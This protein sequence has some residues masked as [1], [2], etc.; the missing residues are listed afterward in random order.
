[1]KIFVFRENAYQRAFA[2]E[3]AL[4]NE[5]EKQYSGR[6]SASFPSHSSAS[7]VD[8]GQRSHGGK[9]GGCVRI[10]QWGML[11]ILLSRDQLESQIGHHFLGGQ[12]S[13]LPGL[14]LT[15]IMERQ[16]F[17]LTGTDT[18]SGYRCAFSDYNSSASTTVHRLTESLIHRHGILHTL[19]LLTA[20]MCNNRLTHGINWFHH[21]PITWE[22]PLL[23]VSPLQLKPKCWW[24]LWGSS[25]SSQVPWLL[26]EVSS[27]QLC[28]ENPCFLAVSRGLFSAPG[29]LSG[30][31]HIDPPFTTGLFFF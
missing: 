22:Y 10:Q 27:L 24:G 29:V 26:A 13:H 19:L 14:H 6:H 15:S 3:E 25:A 23:R 5:V 16:R 11:V 20:K 1:M 18:Y 21:I 28:E 17:I 7:S 30:P 2:A 9:D 31:C 12:A 8:P 4:N